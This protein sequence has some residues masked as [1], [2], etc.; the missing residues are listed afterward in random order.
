MSTLCWMYAKMSCCKESKK[1]V[2][3]YETKLKTEYERYLGAMPLQLVLI[4]MVQRSKVGTEIGERG[5][6]G[7]AV[8]VEQSLICSQLFCARGNLR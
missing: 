2:S 3:N 6:K 8:R 4:V 1:T 7:V 5:R